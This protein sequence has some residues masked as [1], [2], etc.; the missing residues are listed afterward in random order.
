MASQLSGKTI[1]FLVTT[2]GIEQVELTE[3]WAAVEQGRRHPAARL[4]RQRHGPG[5]QP[6]G[7]ADTFPVDATVTTA[8][9]AAVR[10]AGAARR[11]RQPGLPAHPAG[12]GRLRPRRS[13]R[14]Q[15]GRG[16]LPRPW[17]LVEADVVRGRTLTCW[18]SLQTD[19]RNAGAHLGR[20]GGRRRHRGRHTLITSRKPDDLKAFCEALVTASPAER[21]GTRAR[22]ASRACPYPSARRGRPAPACPPPTAPA[23]S[24]APRTRTA[25]K[26]RGPVTL[27][28]GQVAADTTDQRLLDTRGP[29]DWVHTDPWRVLRIQTEFVE[30]F[31]AL[32]ELGRAV[33]VFGSARTPVDTPEYALGRAA[34]RG[35]GRGRVR[36]HHRRRAGRDGGRQQGR[37]GGRRDVAWGSAS[38]CPSSRR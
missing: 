19:L 37:P 28:R 33:S 14:G 4:H 15:A 1:A 35:A 6:P 18:P 29:S 8:D 9:P 21:R 27:R 7:R 26:Q 31:G 5:L 23:P 22:V 20:R 25:E 36:G 30:G 10:R 12:G 24:T 32:A 13:S 34:R 38:S 16:D 11:R 17:T 2:E 3:P